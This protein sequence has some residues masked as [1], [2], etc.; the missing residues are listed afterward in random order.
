MQGRFLFQQWLV[1]TAK[2]D[3]WWLFLIN[4]RS[5][6]ND[7]KFFPATSGKLFLLELFWI[8]HWVGQFKI[9]ASISPPWLY[10]FIWG[11]RQLFFQWC[12]CKLI[13]SKILRGKLFEWITF[14]VKVILKRSCI[15][16]WLVLI[17]VNHFVWIIFFFWMNTIQ[18]LKSFFLIWLKP[19][20]KL[21]S[22]L[23]KQTCLFFLFL[24]FGETSALLGISHLFILIFNFF[25]ITNAI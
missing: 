20:F 24:C 9:W 4:M 22:L 7:I 16:S 17:G 6:L 8:F 18:F 11:C 1:L 21:Q 19:L 10:S 3:F 12:L 2:M 23:W 14:K 5:F 13:C 25:I 15:W